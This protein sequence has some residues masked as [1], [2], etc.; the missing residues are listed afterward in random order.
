MIMPSFN[1]MYAHRMMWTIVQFI[2]LLTCF[3][4][5]QYIY[6]SNIGPDQRA[7]TFFQQTDCYLISKNLPE[8]G[9]LVHRYRADFLISYA[10]NHMEYTT[11]V[12]GNGLDNSFLSD[13][14]FVYAT[15]DGFIVGNTYPCWYNPDQPKQIMLLPREN[16][17]STLPLS[18]PIMV[19]LI[20]L[21]YFLRNIAI[22]SGT[23]K[24]KTKELI[25]ERRQSKKH[26]RHTNTH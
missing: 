11:W 7:S 21:Y 18:V 26:D 15:F 9:R 17:S 10:V 4:Y 14:D 2:I 22:L 20:I 25:L 12:S 24:S 3:A 19:G 13:R 16:W 8:T 1:S 5:S 23:V 6:F